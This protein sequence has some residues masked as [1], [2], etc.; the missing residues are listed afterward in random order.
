M[1][2]GEM[3]LTGF[4]LLREPARHLALV[5]AR[6]LSHPDLNYSRRLLGRHRRRLLER[7]RLPE[8]NGY[9]RG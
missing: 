2:V 6:D 1:P 8:L 9:N 5:L 4:L 7:R 3:C